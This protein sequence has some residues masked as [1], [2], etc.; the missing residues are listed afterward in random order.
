[1]SILK[2]RNERNTKGLL[3]LISS[4]DDNIIMAEVGC[5]A[6]ESTEFFMKSKK[7]KILY[8]IDLWAD[9]LSNYENILSTHNFNEVENEFDN[10]MAVYNIVKM[11]M[12]LE[13]ALP[14]LPMLDAIYI[15]ANH[16]FDFVLADLLHAAKKVKQGGII[17]GH[18]YA[19][20]TPGVIKAVNQ[21]F[22]KPDIIFSDSSWLIKV[23]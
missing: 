7:I 16:D 1:M 22:E 15:D 14:S 18:D 9:P 20:E 19:K 17:A 4:L 8:A 23:K 6:G 11:K 13:E 2:M 5:Y 21:V 3:D 10:K 12:P